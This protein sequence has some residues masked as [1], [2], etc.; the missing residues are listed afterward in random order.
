MK[1]V[2]LLAGLVWILLFSVPA[3]AQENST[4]AKVEDK[5]E[6]N[7]MESADLARQTLPMATR[8]P[9]MP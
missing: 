3:F 6:I 5:K 4:P 1:R 7:I 9:G 2:N 8:E